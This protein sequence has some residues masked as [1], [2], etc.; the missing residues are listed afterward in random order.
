[1]EARRGSNWPREKKPFK[2]SSKTQLLPHPNQKKVAAF[3]KAASSSI[4]HLSE[5]ST[6]SIPSSQIHRHRIVSRFDVKGKYGTSR[7]VNRND[8][9]SSTLRMVQGKSESCAFR[10][11]YGDNGSSEGRSQSTTGEDYHIIIHHCS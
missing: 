6:A 8:C 3:V 9:C 2:E 5:F 1:M 7:S 11:F 4:F 10:G